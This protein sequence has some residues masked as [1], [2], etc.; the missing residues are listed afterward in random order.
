MFISAYEKAVDAIQWQFMLKEPHISY[1][2]GNQMEISFKSIFPI[3]NIY[4][5][6][7][8]TIHMMVKY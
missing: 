4:R 8:G 2:I 1:Q 7:Q 3:K 5:P 6:Y